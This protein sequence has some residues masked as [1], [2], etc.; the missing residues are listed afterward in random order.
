MNAIRLARTVTKCYSMRSYSMAPCEILELLEAGYQRLAESD[1]QSLLKKH[2]TK[3]IFDKLKTKVTPSYCSTLLDCIQ[4]GLCNHDS[5]VGIYAPDPEAYKTFAD[6]FDPIISDIHKGF[7]KANKHPAS[8]YGYGADFPNLDPEQKYVVSTRVRCARS[9]Q[10]FPFNPCLSEEDY[11]NLECMISKVLL[12]F[13]HEHSGK[14]LP[15]KGM[16]KEVQKKLIDNHYLFKE[17]DRFLQAANASRFWP[18]GRGIFMNRDRTFM[19]WV[20]EEDHIR[21]ISM[22]RGGDLGRAYER[23]IIGLESLAFSLKFSCDK[24]LGNL[25]FCPS[26]LGNTIRASVH[27]RLPHIGKDKA[28]LEELAGKH[29]LQ[30]RGTSGEHSEAKDGVY[31]ISNK[32]RMGLT[33]YQTI[34]EMHKGISA[35]IEAECRESSKK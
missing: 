35:L 10:D 26:N 20:N 6:I 2:L 11:R 32:R 30:V 9:I 14:Y 15:L 3:S 28:K 8:C 21:V 34:G 25:T 16:D 18:T 33:E 12:T 13:C 1:S 24:R 5:A 17:G 19:V 27:I 22:E 23:M 7:G 4:S 31:D 29:N